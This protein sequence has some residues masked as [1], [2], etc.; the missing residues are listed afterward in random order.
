MTAIDVLDGGLLTTV[1]DLGRVGAQQ[2]GVPVS[3]AM[4][5]WALRAANRL[6]GNEDGAAAL[7]ITLAGPVLRFDGPGV[8]AVTGGDLGARLDGQ[9]MASWQA[10]GVAAGAE[11]SFAGVRDG[12]RAYLGIAGGI[13]VPLVLGSRST[14]LTARLGGF[15]GRALASGDRVPVGQGAS[16]S[17]RAGWGL[18]RDLVPA[19]G[20]AH[21]VRV[22]MGP[23]DDAFTEAGVR[24]FL[25][26]SFT[27]APQSDRV[28]CRL[29][30]PRIAHRRGADIVSDGT[31]F[32]AVQVSGDGRPI[33][34]MA[35]RGTTGGY[36]KIATVASADLPRLAQ[37]AP[38]D[39]V[40]FVRAGLDEAVGALRASRAE[41]DRIGREEPWSGL[42]A[43]LFEEDSGAPLAAPAYAVLA[44]ALGLRGGRT[45]VRA[46]T[47]RAAMPG[48]V[49]SVIVRAG[50]EVSAG[51]PLV[52]LEAMKMQ[53]PVRAPRT[54]RVSRVLVAEGALVESGEALVEFDD[55]DPR[56]L[57]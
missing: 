25:S 21:T 6:V 24:T 26:E 10:I 57:T 35:D 5:T 22:V 55:A 45:A 7:E 20:H 13:A 17:D 16:A 40:R 32:G 33:V 31:A 56:R 34:L 12:L 1:Q 36:T 27:L 48:L 23:Q 53:N 9:P 18:P 46:G 39:R 3:G 2:Y 52:V 44:A 29:S 30:G 51:Q 15:G 11:L 37:A 4:D 14:L 50:D 42:A 41:L 54:G 19:Y 28:G 8:I 47:V 43:G 38:G 49:V